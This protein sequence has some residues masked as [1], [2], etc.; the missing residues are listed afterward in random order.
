MI[1]KHVFFFRIYLCYWL[2]T[3]SPGLKQNI[4]FRSQLWITL[5]DPQ[6][7]FQVVFSIVVAE[8]L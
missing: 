4:T 7:I 1:V 3:F 5:E 8:D 2:Q 6:Y